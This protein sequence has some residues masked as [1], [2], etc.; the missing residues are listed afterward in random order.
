LTAL[1]GT[2]TGVL[3]LNIDQWT[4]NAKKAEQ[5]MGQLEQ[6]VGK[7]GGALGKLKGA[8][9]GLGD[10]FAAPFLIGVKAAADLEQNIANVNASLGGL[11][12]ST[13]DQLADS[14]QSIGSASKFSANEVAL[15]ADELAKAGYTAKQITGGTLQTVVDL[16]Q[17]TGESLQTA[18]AGVVQAMAVWNPAIVGMETG[19]T[20]VTR[21][22]DIF[23]VAANQSAGGVADVIA[24]L[25]PL[26]P[27]AAS[28]GVGF[29]QS[30]AA[31][32]L[33]TQA[34]LSGAEAGTSLARGLTNLAN[35]TSEAATLMTDLGIAAFDSQGNFVGFPSL[36]DQLKTS[37]GGMSDQAQLAALSTIFG[38]EAM[39]VMGLA[40]LNGS[41]P[42]EAMIA[43]MQEQGVAAEQS[44]LRMDTLSAQFGSLKEGAVTL[45]AAFAE[46]LVPIFRQLVDVGNA[47]LDVF[48]K[49]PD[50]IKQII[51]IVGGSLAM[52]SII[53][54]SI[55]SYKAI[56]GILNAMGGGATAA[57]FGF[58]TL[59]AAIG[60]VVAILAGL[61]IAYSYNFLGFRDFVGKVVDGG[62]GILG[63]FSDLKD[64]WDGVGKFFE[65]GGQ[66]VSSATKPMSAFQRAL[67]GANKELDA[68]AN[69]AGGTWKEFSKFEKATFAAEFALGKLIDNDAAPDWLRDIAKN[70]RKAIPQIRNF[71]KFLG[72]IWSG[73]PRKA[74][75][76]LAL[77]PPSLQKIAKNLAPAVTGV[78]DLVSAFQVGGFGS[79][80]REIPQAF[81][82]IGESIR[83]FV[84]DMTGGLSIE[85]WTLTVAAPTI[86][87]WLKDAASDAWGFIATAAGWA[88]DGIVELGSWAVNVVAPAVLGAAQD[89]FGAVQ[90]WVVNTAWPAVQA[91]AIVIG[92]VLIDIASWAAG[93]V[94]DLLS[95]M[96]GHVGAAWDAIKSVGFRIWDVLINIGSWAKG[97]VSDI[98]PYVQS[99][100]SSA[101]DTAKSSAVTIW[102]VL[103]NLGSFSKG[104]VSDIW[105][106]V[107]SFA[108][109]AWETAKAGAVTIWGVLTNVGSFA[110]GIVSDIWPYVSSFAAD[111]W[112]AVKSTAIT[113]WGVLVDIGSWAKGAWSDLKNWVVANV[114]VEWDAN[115][116]ADGIN[117][118]T[119][120]VTIDQWDVDIDW[121]GLNEKL[122]PD[123]VPQST[124]DAAEASG[125]ATGRKAGEAFSDKL[126][127]AWGAVFRGGG[128][129]GGGG[130]SHDYSDLA[131]AWVQGFVGGFGESTS[132]E[133]GPS[134]QGLSDEMQG[135]LQS[136]ADGI[137]GWFDI[138]WPTVSWPSLDI[139]LPA[140]TWP[141][142]EDLIGLV[143]K[144]VRDF[145][146]D[147]I[148]T[149]MGWVSSG[150]NNKRE[151]IG[152]PNADLREGAG[153]GG[154]DVNG[155]L[156]R[157]LPS[158]GA[159]PGAGMTADIEAIGTAFTNAATTINTATT[160]IT[161][162]VATM[163]AGFGTSLQ[164]ILTVV[165]AIFVTA[166]PANIQVGMDT[167]STTITTGVGTWGVNLGTS[168]QTMLT[169]VNAVFVIAV[170]ANI[171]T[172]MDTGSTTISTVAGTWPGLIDAVAPGMGS[173]GLNAGSVAGFGV[174][175][176]MASAEGS[177]SGEANSWP[178]IVD[179]VAGAMG[180]AGYNAGAAA[181][182]GVANGMN[183]ALG[184]IQSAAADIAAIVEN[185]IA[186]QLAIASPSKVT[187][188][189]GEFTGEGF[190]LGIESTVGKVMAAANAVADTAADAMAAAG[191]V[192]WDDRRG[193]WVSTFRDM[194][195][196][197]TE[198]GRPSGG[199][200]PDVPTTPDMPDKD[201]WK[202]IALE[203]ITAGT[204]DALTGSG[205]LTDTSAGS[206]FNEADWLARVAALGD[207]ANN[208]SDFFT[209]R[210]RV[211]DTDFTILGKYLEHYGSPV[212]PTPTD[213]NAP[214]PNTPN[215]GSGKPGV[216]QGYVMV[217]EGDQYVIVTP[218]S[219]QFS[220]IAANA[221]RG[222][223][224]NSTLSRAK[225]QRT[226]AG[227]VRTILGRV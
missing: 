14:F 146:G 46:G 222:D 47:A 176:G 204:S 119:T 147:P 75:E 218:D 4:G 68:A 181:G 45:L 57:S 76:S 95:W 191:N 85:D 81:G 137:G 56:S 135:T 131:V 20:D 112:D 55:Q 120:K 19:L 79:L 40:I 180:S 94:P 87:G 160:G 38:A 145:V 214:L 174:A 100:A 51:G 192:F 82:M 184:S 109:D 50:P 134:L 84:R 34:G 111:A 101:W 194:G 6:S 175:N 143:P 188:K 10:V 35:P 102:G 198:P 185:T 217:K 200:T 7:S 158:T 121:S 172:G 54:R 142:R 92:G 132:K 108:T 196:V 163:S 69:A 197:T 36:F 123:A 157:Q 96:Q 83:L 67:G 11:D 154:I 168:M 193:A 136:W 104:I 22:A 177:I 110:K 66:A 88:W 80:V 186:L 103:T 53:T 213:P 155:T 64:G 59:A 3:Q 212:M 73:S 139:P 26:G 1:L 18:T 221:K 91:T 41:E 209:G 107:Q 72:D 201:D 116:D 152:N 74:M 208:L 211:N 48:M 39:D 86:A 144:D 179:G 129:G 124:I 166:I 65:K 29:D 113:L 164:P 195:G 37:M 206:L 225:S 169:A 165:N 210:T 23:T 162:S 219:D 16:A 70:T 30:A 118:G 153:I 27:V 151:N 167:A 187:R 215:N 32:A 106:Y 126:K 43:L 159:G 220:T 9:L 62:R 24:G 105:P 60:A 78:R 117:L 52:F 190:A 122:G 224:A 140:I 149:V 115:K 99:F 138:S 61:T 90:D 13:L 8:A 71:G 15:V 161:A 49:I 171:Q 63:F 182:F 207:A 127:E 178:G 21:A 205:L 183:S 12:A 93:K 173:S 216:S 31:I 97:V 226:Q 133:L 156:I 33:F 28:M 77:L 2:A 44:A 58:G 114:K 170:P 202:D 128:S 89:I 150:G 125:E 17:A 42:L 148:G 25:R 98:W 199:T 5:S 141:S 203:G 189:L 227:G 223:I 130:A